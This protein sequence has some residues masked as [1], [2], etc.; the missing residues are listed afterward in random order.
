MWEPRRLTTL[1]AS[2]AYYREIFAV[3]D[4]EET[5]GRDNAVCLGIV[6]N[7]FFR[8]TKERGSGNETFFEKV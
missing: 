6:I 2:T 3:I 7:E 8:L 4:S 5:L 1:W